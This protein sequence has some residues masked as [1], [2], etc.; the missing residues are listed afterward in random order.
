MA[1]PRRVQTL[2]A[3]AGSSTG[4]LLTAHASANTKASSWT[5]LGVLDINALMLALRIGI[6]SSSADCLID[7]ALGAANDQQIV[8]EN[9][10][11]TSPNVGRDP[12]A[13]RMPLR[14]PKGTEV[15]A[16]MQASTGGVTMHAL[17]Y[18]EAG[19]LALGA[20]KILTL[21]A[22]TA[23]SGGTLIDPGGSAGTVGAKVQL[24]ASVARELMAFGVAFGHA[25]D[26]I[27]SA[28]VWHVFVYLGAAN[29]EQ[30]LA[31]IDVNAE[32]LRDSIQPAWLGPLDVSI[33]KGS[34]ISV[35][36]SCSITTSDNLFDVV[37][38][39]AAR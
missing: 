19:P 30:V 10:L 11:Y 18:A 36:A 31:E 25:G 4:T 1:A 5:S 7:L 15:W 26:Y 28:S 17:A 14:V 37:F 6:P 35:A 12:A 29:D 34:R 27:R 8:V 2:G 39:G 32:N 13:F 23:D 21:G 3:V 38:Y 20:G 22:T 16:K 24:T 9:I 33:P